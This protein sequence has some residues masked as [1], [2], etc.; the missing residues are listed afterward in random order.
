MT[1]NRRPSAKLGGITGQA[2]VLRSVRLLLSFGR[3]H[4]RKLSHF[5]LDILATDRFA[6]MVIIEIKKSNQTAR[7]ALQTRVR[8]A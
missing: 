1:P 2:F 3:Q 6:A 4:R 7:Q 5:N 8:S